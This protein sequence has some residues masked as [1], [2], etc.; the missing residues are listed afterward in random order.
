MTI[1]NVHLYREMRLYYPGIQ[2]ASH[3][4]AA[5]FARLQPTGKAHTIEDC[6]GYDTAALVYIAGDDEYAQTKLIDFLPNPDLLG[7]LRH[8]L[9]TEEGNWEGPDDEPQRM[10]AARAAV[11]AAGADE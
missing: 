9:E 1:Y 8:A 3:E 10:T 11:A 5:E 7:I 6:N 4:E 2:A